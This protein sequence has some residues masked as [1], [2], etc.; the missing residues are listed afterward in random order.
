MKDSISYNDFSPVETTQ[1]ENPPFLPGFFV[2]KAKINETEVA[3]YVSDDFSVGNKKLFIVQNLIIQI[4]F[5]YFSHEPF[6]Q[7]FVYHRH[8][9]WLMLNIWQCY[10]NAQYQHVTLKLFPFN[11]QQKIHMTFGMIVHLSF[12]CKLSETN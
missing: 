4:S 2:L 7:A 1:H 11:R 6:E 10:H 9:H 5:L 8:V 12:Y 3:R